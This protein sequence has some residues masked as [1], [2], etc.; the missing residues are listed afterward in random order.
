MIKKLLAA[1]GALL[2]INLAQAAAFDGPFVQLGVGMGT[3]QQRTEIEETAETAALKIDLGNESAVGQLLAGYSHRFDNSN[4]NLAG[5]IYYNIGNSH[6]GML[7]GGLLN[8][9]LKNTYGLAIEPGYYLTEETLGYLKLGVQRG[10]TELYDTENFWNGSSSANGFV[11]GAGIKQLVASNIY[12]GIEFTH[13]NYGNKNFGVDA[14]GLTSQQSTQTLGLVT[15]G[16]LFN[17]NNPDYVSSHEGGAFDGP[18]L[19]I[20]LGC[21]INSNVYKADNDIDEWDFSKDRA[22]GELLAGYSK[23]FGAFNLAANIHYNLGSLNSGNYIA[24]GVETW[25]TKLKNVWGMTLEPGY[26]LTNT[27][28]AFL[29]LG[30]ERA[31][32]SY[33]DVVIDDPYSAGSRGTDGISYGFGL[34][35][36]MTGHIYVGVEVTR[37]EFSKKT[38]DE[39]QYSFTLKPTQ[40]LGL[41]TIGYQF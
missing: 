35:Q 26:Y 8:S 1:I 24:D 20:G 19:Q 25:K 14:F 12:A 23:S 27:S 3:K 34:K 39:D 29:K 16:Y 6:S 32:T 31:D 15:A 18:Y 5:D 17:K 37:S 38:F 2:I 11:Y 30:W 21:A 7:Q 9:K 36:L 33:T 28:L 10:K 13:T 41:L 4:F 22:A 40:T